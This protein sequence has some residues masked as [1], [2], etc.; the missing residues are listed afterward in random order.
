[1]NNKCEVCE[2]ITCDVFSLAFHQIQT[3]QQYQ[4][5]LSYYDSNK[6]RRRLRSHVLIEPWQQHC[7]CSHVR[8]NG[9]MEEALITWILSP[10]KIHSFKYSNHKLHEVHM[11]Q[12]HIWGYSK[13]IAYFMN[14]CIDAGNSRKGHSWSLKLKPTNNSSVIPL[15]L[16]L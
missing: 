3:V 5:V 15:P 13:L 2:T 7:K 14:N 12:P 10:L 6:S 8:I 1:M 16:S 9:K 4:Q 11:A